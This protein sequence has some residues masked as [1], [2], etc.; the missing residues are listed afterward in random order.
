M[1]VVMYFAGSNSLNE[2]MAL[3]PTRIASMMPV[4]RAL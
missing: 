3:E 2:P 4:P 1:F